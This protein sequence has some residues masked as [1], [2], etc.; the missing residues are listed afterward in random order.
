MSDNVA[1]ERERSLENVYKTI[2]EFEKP[3]Y[4]K[5]EEKSDGSLTISIDPNEMTNIDNLESNLMYDPVSYP[6]YRSAFNRR[7]KNSF[8]R[9]ISAINIKLLEK[10]LGKDKLNEVVRKDQEL[11]RQYLE[12][13]KELD[14][15]N[16]G[17]PDRIDID[18]TRNSIQ[19][20]K[21]LDIVKNST[22]A[23]TERYNKDKENQQ[24]R[25]YNQD[26]ER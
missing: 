11:K 22:S 3:H 24:K 23:D 20:I 7:Y 10:E 19:S 26:L 9:N 6:S 21:D 18:D 15:D 12:A 17:V 16:D 2:C 1:L 14:L 8:K 4:E 25:K 5:I 13:T